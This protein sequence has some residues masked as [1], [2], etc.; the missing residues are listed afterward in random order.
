MEE[1]TVCR[2]EQEKRLVGKISFEPLGERGIIKRTA[3]EK[4]FKLS[5]LEN[6]RGVSKGRGTRGW[7]GRQRQ[8]SLSSTLRVASRGVP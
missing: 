7:R 4:C 2:W 5:G 8:I 1:Y 6:G 3:T